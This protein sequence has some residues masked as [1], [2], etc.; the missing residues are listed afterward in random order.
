MS[1][2]GIE[3]F[4]WEEE[5]A[6]LSIVVTRATAATELCLSDG[7]GEVCIPITTRSAREIAVALLN[8]ADDPE[9]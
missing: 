3:R 6:R 4:L 1:V 2:G 7:D 9:P 8:W 5:N